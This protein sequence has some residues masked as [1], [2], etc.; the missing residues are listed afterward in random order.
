MIWSQLHDVPPPAIAV[1][2]LVAF[3]TC[4]VI[5]SAFVSLWRL[6]WPRQEGQSNPIPQQQPVELKASGFPE[7]EASEVRPG[8]ALPSPRQKRLSEAAAMAIERELASAS[9]EIA[10]WG[11]N[12]VGVGTVMRRL[13]L[14]TAPV[15][16]ESS[17]GKQERSKY[18]KAMASASGDLKAAYLCAAAYLGT[19]IE[20]SRRADRPNP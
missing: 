10:Q 9:N 6:N 16:I 20:A 14:T 5:A 7:G 1:L 18:E 3:A 19:L 11:D 2:S 8:V 17:L 4:L 15:F 13:V 12:S